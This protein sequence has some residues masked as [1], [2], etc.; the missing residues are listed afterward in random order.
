MESEVEL[1]ETL[2]ELNVVATCPDLYPAMVDLGAVP[3]M[4][5]LLSHENTDIA[6]A[7]ADLLQELTDVDIL[8]ESQEGADTLID[9][10]LEQQACALLVQN[11]E[12]LDESVKEESDGVHNTLGER[13]PDRPYV[14]D[15]LSPLKLDDFSLL[16]SGIRK[17]SRVQA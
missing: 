8:H 14:L 11:L 15:S 5:E 1:H 9:A 17:P 12:R 10:L 2:R 13:R 6:V 7:V 4:L 3:S 16:C